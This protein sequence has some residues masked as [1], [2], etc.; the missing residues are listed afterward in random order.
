MGLQRQCLF[1]FSCPRTPALGK[2]E[3]SL[4]MLPNCPPISNTNPSPSSPH[5]EASPGHSHLALTISLKLGQLQGNL[6]ILAA[7]GNER[8]VSPAGVAHEGSEQGL[9]WRMG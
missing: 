2:G 1:R 8:E 9:G 4:L 6:G 7:C 3:R 5:P